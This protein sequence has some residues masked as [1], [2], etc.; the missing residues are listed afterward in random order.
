MR[1]REVQL[2][3][4][5]PRDLVDEVLSKLP[6]CAEGARNFRFDL[7]RPDV[8]SFELDPDV[9][10]EEVEAKVLKLVRGMI[11]GWRAVSP[12][13]KFDR[14][15][16]EPPFSGDIW[17]A[18]QARGLV[19]LLAPGQ[20]L[21]S[22]VVLDLFSYFDRYFME[23]GRKLGGAEVRYPQMIGVDVLKR[24]QYFSSFPH[25]VTFCSH[26]RE[27]VDVLT[28]FADK[29][30]RGEEFPF[31][32][33]LRPPAYAI[34]PAVCF[35]TYHSLAD[36]DIK[37]PRVVTTVARCFRYESTAMTS[38][39]RLWDFT[40]R[41]IV[42]V[43][44]APWVREQRNLSLEAMTRFVEGLGLRAWIEA[45]NDPF[46]INNFVAKKYHQLLTEAKY[47]LKL[48][49]PFTGGA[50]AAASF[51]YHED[52]FGRAFDVALDGHPV[53]TGCTAFGIERWVF[54]F[55]SQ[56]GLDP[57]QWPQEVRDALY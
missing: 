10:A 45:A 35:H 52:F 9:N 30:A 44:P 5:V 51:N 13:V 20:A 4:P 28:S 1:P 38:L 32:E 49:L 41:E 6:Y 36:Q 23:L 26:L 48:S 25:H 24:C 7:E 55:L 39:E 50:L 34:N 54:A 40:M 12:R 47:E 37:T 27:D 16:I 3:K 43:G 8:V 15:D 46:F 18:L 42:F 17:Q 21:L 57:A 2:P 31:E 19:R 22:G 14:R 56:F 29:Q 53:H 33:G 11:T